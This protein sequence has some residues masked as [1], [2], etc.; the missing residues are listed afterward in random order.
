M[1]RVK[2]RARAKK[3]K[4]FKR[5][6]KISKEDDSDGYLSTEDEIEENDNFIGININKQYII[7]KY[8]GR[9]SFSKT[10]LVYDYLENIF[11]ALKIFDNN[12]FDELDNE[13]YYFK[14]I[15][16]GDTN[17]IKFYGEIE[18]KKG[19]KYNKGILLELL[20]DSL[21]KFLENEYDSIL[22]L[23]I[24]KKIFKNIVKG[25]SYI[26]NQGLVHNDLKLDNIL[27]SKPNK[28]VL[29]YMNKIKDLKIDKYYLEK[30]NESTPEEIKLLDKNK[31]KMVK[32]KIK[33]KVNKELIKNFK[34]KIIKLN[35]DS[36][37]NLKLEIND[38]E[39][40]Q[41]E[42]DQSEL[43]QRELDQNELL[44]KPEI[45]LENLDI[46]IIDLGNAE[47]IGDM[48]C[49][50]ILTRSYRPPENILNSY[51]DNKSDIWV[52]GCLLY[53]LVN[54]NPLFDLSE[55]GVTGIEKD[56]I[57][58]SQMYEVLGKIPKDIALECEY[59]EELFDSKCRI[60]KNK[61]INIRDI[62]EELNNRINLTEIENE[63]IK[64]ILIK[65]LDYD[66]N[67]RPSCQELLEDSWFF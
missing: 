28:K 36:L 48:E 34:N 22:T 66:Y 61:N 38:N 4:Y 47:L 13:V 25:V 3:K 53:E 42:L 20:G 17:I 27:L 67:S 8:L 62:K 24:I 21:T 10:W 46:K 32:R 44:K 18:F 1:N 16:N 43:D 40:N 56:R 45:N 9:G 2:L 59:S 54:G 30:L 31:R 39:E 26:H 35:N 58:I 57:H 51:Y 19:D 5:I 65:I 11:L 41:N 12:Y 60:I 49:D 63:E 64:N 15:N 33:E 37:E 50:E 23:D 6:D 7:T 14:K 55:C 52:I 29:D